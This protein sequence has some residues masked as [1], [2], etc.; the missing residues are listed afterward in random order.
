VARV[1]YVGQ[2]PEVELRLPDETVIAEK[3]KPVDVPAA[4][5]NDL[6]EQENWKKTGG[7]K[8]KKKQTRKKKQTPKETSKKEDS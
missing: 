8:S 2:Y 7:G 6:A 1:T 5:A 4:I 3:G